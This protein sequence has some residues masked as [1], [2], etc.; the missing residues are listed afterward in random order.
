[1]A[2]TLPYPDLVFVPLDILTAE[3]QNEIVA[4]YTYIANQFPIAASNIDFS[5]FTSTNVYEVNFSLT[6]DVYAQKCSYTVPSAGKYLVI[7]DATRDTVAYDSP[8]YI[9]V[10]KNSTAVNGSSYQTVPAGDWGFISIARIVSCAQGD[11]ISLG[12]L[13]TYTVS[14]SSNTHVNACI[15][16]IG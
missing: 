16:K 3:E 7:G 10:N 13:S 4:N 14:A 9:R 5:T 6:A 12:L 8:F 15:V 1:M 11:V 2:L